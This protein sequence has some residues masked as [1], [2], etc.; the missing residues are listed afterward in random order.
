ME[1]LKKI[2]KI[3]GF[4]L[5]GLFAAFVVYANWEEPPLSDRLNLKPIELVVF[6]LNR[7]ISSQDSLMIS[8]QLTENKGVTASTVNP[9]AKTVSVTYHADETTEKALKQ[10]VESSDFQAQ[11]VD[12]TAFQGPQCPVPMEYIDF[13]L[14]TKKA[15]CFR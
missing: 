5:L 3:T 15:L 13:I 9:S 10:S 7:E 6:T 12:F 2:F 14:N 8:N 11:K 1:K 4:T